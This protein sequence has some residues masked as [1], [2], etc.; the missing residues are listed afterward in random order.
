MS[1]KIGKIV[2]ALVSSKIQ[3]S[4]AINT[5]IDTGDLVSDYKI[6]I[7]LNETHNQLNNVEK[8]PNGVYGSINNSIIRQY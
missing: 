1:P 2:G 4:L 3:N 6:S 8:G 5:T 7:F